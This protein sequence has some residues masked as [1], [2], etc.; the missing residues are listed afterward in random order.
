MWQKKDE[1]NENSENNEDG[2]VLL[3]A[4]HP[5]KIQSL[6]KSAAI[7]GVRHWLITALVV[8]ERAE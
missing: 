1:N 7:L 2:E 3:H 5:L 8:A 6:N 4:P